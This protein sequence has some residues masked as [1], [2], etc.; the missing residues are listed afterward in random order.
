MIENSYWANTNDLNYSYNSQQYSLMQHSFNYD[1][2]IVPSHKHN[3]HYSHFSSE[4]SLKTH[5]PAQ[6][7]NFSTG[8]NYVN[9]GALITFSKHESKKETKPMKQIK[10]KR[11]C[12]IFEPES[13]VPETRIKKEI[14]SNDPNSSFSSIISSESTESSKNEGKMRRFSPKQRQ[15]A[16]QRERDRTH[17]VNTAFIQLRN[18]IPTE[19]LDRKL[20]K[21]ETL[22]L[23]GSYINH[24]HSI[25]VMPAEYSDDPCL[26]KQK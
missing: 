10:K 26:H 20:S 4:S 22:R 8:Q 14:I 3:Y 21:I 25:L 19:P 24:L 16:N 13:V 6:E 12:Q 15:V 1:P 7:C 9:K 11:K 18:L 17:S 23:A 5:L 2:S